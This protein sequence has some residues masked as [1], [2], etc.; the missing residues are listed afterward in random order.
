ME[1]ACNLCDFRYGTM[2]DSVLSGGT[3]VCGA[4][5]MRKERMVDAGYLRS[6]CIQRYI[7]VWMTGR[8]TV[9]NVM[10]RTS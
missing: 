3:F 5:Q 10:R 8:L 4:W 7:Y 9:K 6:D 2:I 1:S